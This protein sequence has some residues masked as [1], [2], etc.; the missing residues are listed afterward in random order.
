MEA[1]DNLLA[2]RSSVDDQKVKTMLRFQISLV[3]NSRTVVKDTYLF[4]PGVCLSR[5][6]TSAC[7]FV[8][9]GSSSGPGEYPA[10]DEAPDSNLSGVCVTIADEHGMTQPHWTV[11]LRDTQASQAIFRQEDSQHRENAEDSSEP[12]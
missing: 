7:I 3:V 11:I 6:S 10:G 12:M 9:S 2:T 1:C 8:G 5:S 4:V